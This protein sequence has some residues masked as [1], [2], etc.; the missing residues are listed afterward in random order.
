[1]SVRLKSQEG[2]TII[3]YDSDSAIATSKNLV[4]H[5]KTKHIKIKYHFIREAQDEVEV[6]LVEIKGEDQLARHF[7]KTPS[8][9]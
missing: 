6:K 2:A 4:F 8:K 9:G 3:Y 5:L 1:M 7:Y